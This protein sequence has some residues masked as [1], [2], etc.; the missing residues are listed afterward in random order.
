MDKN[1]SRTT[2]TSASIKGINDASAQAMCSSLHSTHADGTCSCPPA[3]CTYCAAKLCSA[4][5]HSPP[6]KNC[7]VLSRCVRVHVAL[8]VLVCVC[9]LLALSGDVLVFLRL[10]RTR[11][12]S[13][14]LLGVCPNT[15]LPAGAGR[16]LHA[17][18]WFGGSHAWTGSFAVSEAS[19]EWAHG[20]SH[21][22]SGFFLLVLFSSAPLVGG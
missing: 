14:M 5:T 6:S 20:H 1:G 4:C 9:G 17:L 15:L 2:V 18:I 7:S 10:G 8:H 22:F 11:A 12:V 3:G 13:I 21:G 16:L 19:V